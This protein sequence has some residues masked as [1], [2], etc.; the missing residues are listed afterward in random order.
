MF[1]ALFSWN[2]YWRWLKS[3]AA[4]IGRISILDEAM[5]GHS[6]YTATINGYV[7]CGFWSLYGFS[8][9]YLFLYSTVLL[10]NRDTWKSTSDG[11]F[12]SIWLVYL[13]QFELRL[14]INVENAALHHTLDGCS[15]LPKAIYNYN[16]NL[17][18]FVHDL[19]FTTSSTI[20]SHGSPCSS[21]RREAWVCID[22][23]KRGVL[24]STCGFSRRC[25]LF[26]FLGG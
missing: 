23:W 10:L 24:S 15:E 3:E 8:Q 21:S 25:I 26:I 11:A 17:L 22:L 2:G 7:T 12:Y 5:Y 9:L 20:T 1:S 16:L 19:R 14:T 13:V 4:C 18:I 6:F